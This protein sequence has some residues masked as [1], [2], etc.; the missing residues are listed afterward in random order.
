V[1]ESAH[2][3]HSLDQNTSCC[4]IPC[5]KFKKRNKIAPQPSEEDIIHEAAKRILMRKISQRD[6]HANLND[7]VKELDKKE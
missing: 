7:R 1:A 4:C 3:I 5:L 2:R 6:D